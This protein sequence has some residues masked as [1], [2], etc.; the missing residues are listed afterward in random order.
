[1]IGI[2]LKYPDLPKIWA[3]N[4]YFERIYLNLVVFYIFYTFY[5]CK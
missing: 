1:M 5:M 3:K 2:G 4:G